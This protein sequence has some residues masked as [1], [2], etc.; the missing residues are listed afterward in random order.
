[1]ESYK[2]GTVVCRPEGSIYG[3]IQG[4]SGMDGRNGFLG[5]LQKLYGYPMGF[6]RGDPDPIQ[7]DGLVTVRF[8]EGIAGLVGHNNSAHYTPEEM[9]RHFVVVG[10]CESEISRIM[11]ELKTLEGRTDMLSK[12]TAKRLKPAIQFL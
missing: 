1:M 7:D 9:G 8:M 11:D 12:I 6:I 5:L 3:R 4:K 2:P 10:D